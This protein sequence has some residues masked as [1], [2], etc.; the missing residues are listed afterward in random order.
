MKMSVRKGWVLAIMA[1]GV[2]GCIPNTDYGHGADGYRPPR[3]ARRE[4]TRTTL[5]PR[6]SPA[7]HQ[8]RGVTPASNRVTTSIYTV[9]DGDTLRG[10]ASATGTGAEAI[11]HANNLPLDTQL[12]AGQRLTIPGGLYHLIH[13][14][15]TGIGIALA[16]GAR[17]SDIVDA[18]DLQEP[19]VL[20]A[21]RRILIP[22]ATAT[23][24][25]VRPAP[26]AAG[27]DLGDL[28]TGGDEPAVND[29]DAPPPRTAPKRPSQPAEAGWY[30]GGFSW[31]VV[32]GSVVSR[33]GSMVNGSRSDGIKIAVPVGTPVRAAADG[34]VIYTSTNIPGLGGIVMIRHEGNWI[35]VYGH[36]SRITVKRDQ[37]VKH[38]Q[39]IAYSG[40]S[41][42]ADRPELHFEL[43][44]G[45]TPID[46]LS[47]LPRR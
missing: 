45:R 16:Y 24:A 33:F 12:S 4:P 28:A 23:P 17:W 13:P 36:N 22:G 3:P 42:L 38:G 44:Q 47:K 21:G 14:G 34:T 43:R 35:S 30:A 32:G 25:P 9:R 29:N 7:N 5:P 46:P 27:P 10:I 6:P 19:Y 18:N 8:A 20:R 41:G 37:V 1:M 31:P 15:E 11:A 39:L 2:S 26:P 40:Q